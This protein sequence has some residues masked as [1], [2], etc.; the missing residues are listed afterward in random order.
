MS[1][2]SN[3]EGWQ[4][5]NVE[6]ACNAAIR[7]A[8]FYGVDAGELKKLMARCWLEELRERAV[9]GQEVLSS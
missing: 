8:L 5:T 4:Y 2:L 1:G 6:R 3:L 7:E 9:I